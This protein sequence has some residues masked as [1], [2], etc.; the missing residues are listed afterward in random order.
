MYPCVPKK[1]A[2]HSQRA[3][4][5]CERQPSSVLGA[6]VGEVLPLKSFNRFNRRPLAGHHTL[7]PAM[8]GP[9]L[10]G[11]PRSKQSKQGVQAR[12]MLEAREMLDV[13]TVYRDATFPDV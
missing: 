13:S 6:S 7:P 4:Q 8:A 11:K 12:E 2:A 5:Q 9:G 3:S 1:N 10:L